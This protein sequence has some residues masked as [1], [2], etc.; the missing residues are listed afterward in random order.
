MVHN[1]AAVT[2]CWNVEDGQSGAERCWGFPG[3]LLHNGGLQPGDSLGF[4][5]IFKG[6]AQPAVSVRVHS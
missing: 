2:Q 1:G 6:D 3:W 5:G 4:G